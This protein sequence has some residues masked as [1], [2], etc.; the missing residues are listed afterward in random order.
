MYWRINNEIALRSWLRA[1]FAYYVKQEPYAKRLTPEEFSLLG[2]CDGEHDLAE[3]NELKDLCH[4]GL[5]TQCRQGEHPE[6]WSKPRYYDHRY[7]PKMNLMITGKCNYNCRH[8][9][10]AA[11]NAPLMSEWS[12]EDICDLLDQARDCGIHAFTITG[13]EPIVHPKFKEIIEE[14]YKRDMFVEELNT[15]GH[16]I[17]Q[18]MI[19][20]MKDIGCMPLIKISFD[21]LGTHDWMRARTGAEERTLSAV[22]LCTEN[23]FP[24]KIQMQINRKTLPNLMPTVCLMAELGVHEVRLIRTTEVIRWAM[25]GAGLTLPITDYYE[26]MLE[27]ANEHARTGHRM[28]IDIWQFLRLYPAEHRI[29]IVPVMYGKEKYRASAPVCK[30]NRGM[31]A[32]TSEG[33]VVPCLQMSGH[34]I[35][36]D[37]HMASLHTE[38]LRDILTKSAYLDTVCQSVEELRQINKKCGTC[39]Y[40][41][42]C[43][44]GCRALGLLYSGAA[45]DLSGSDQ[46]KCLFFENGWLERI[47][48]T[49]ADW[50]TNL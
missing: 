27:F 46:T 9:F 21:G 49:F 7:F 47:L 39:S 23:G 13:G 17:T 37:I 36:Y 30:D 2:R 34:F 41:I 22:Q 11:D 29:D 33:D 8:C 5:I 26:K 15:N 12:F 44:G 14:I 16:F 10:N 4:R 32:V 50:Q 24:V 35:H 43:T 18:D 40:F 45:F 1:P 3:N 19:T 42:Y 31:V 20:W 25:N 38:K 6:E 28:A 48:N